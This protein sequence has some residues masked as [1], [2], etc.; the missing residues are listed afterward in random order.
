MVFRALFMATR[1]CLIS[2]FL[3]SK[4]KARANFFE[5]LGR[6]QFVVFSHEINCTITW[7]GHTYKNLR[8]YSGDIRKSSEDFEL[9]SECLKLLFPFE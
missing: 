1:Y 9:S 3:I 4:K 7:Q 5:R 6:T 2:S 8:Q